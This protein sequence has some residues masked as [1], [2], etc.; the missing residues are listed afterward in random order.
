MSD[1]IIVD[2][3]NLIQAFNE[4]LARNVSLNPSDTNVSIGLSQPLTAI[5]AVLE[6]SIWASD[7]SFAEYHMQVSQE[8]ESIIDEEAQTPKEAF[9]IKNYLYQE[10]YTTDING[11][12]QEDLDFF[13][14]QKQS[15]FNYKEGTAFYKQRYTN[16]FNYQFGGN[17]SKAFDEK[18]FG[19][20]GKV[21]VGFNDKKYDLNFGIEK[22]FDCLIN[23]NLNYAI[24][25]LEF[26]FDFSKQLKKIKE[27]LSQLERDLNPT[28]IFKMICEVGLNFGKNLICPS[29]LVGI[30]LLLP[31]LFGKYSLDL[32]KIRFDWTIAIGAILKTI[33]GALT[34]FVEN[35]PKLIVPFIDCAINSIR[36]VV[37]YI[38][39]IISTTENLYNSIGGS[40][41]QVTKA[42]ITTFQTAGDAL[43]TIGILDT[44][45]EDA[46]EDMKET[47]EDMGDIFSSIA[48]KRNKLSGGIDVGEYER[49]EA[50]EN[51]V[52]YLKT[53]F[54]NPSLR[55]LSEDEV[56][57]SL[58]E[59]LEDYPS[60]IN[61]V[62]GGYSV[63]DINVYKEI[64]KEKEKLDALTKKYF[65]D[66]QVYQ[67]ERLKESKRKNYFRLD[68]V[69]DNRSLSYP[70]GEATLRIAEKEAFSRLMSEYK[71]NN[72][73]A[74]KDD[75]K[76]KTIEFNE[77]AK[78]LGRRM[79]FK[80]TR[81]VINKTKEKRD[82]AAGINSKNKN[83]L[84]PPGEEW[85][86][87][88]YVFAKYGVDIENKYKTST[89]NLLPKAN[90]AKSSSNNVKEFF[91]TYAIKY[92]LELKDYIMQVTGNIILAYKGIE[93]FLGE[94]VE[95]DLKILGNIQELL[96]VIR[97]FRLIYELSSNGFDNCKKIKENKEVFKAM[98][99]ENNQ[100]LTFDDSTLEKQNLDPADYLALKTKDGR[101]ST[102]IDLNK[103]DEA[104]QHLSVNE[105]NLDSIYEGILN[106]LQN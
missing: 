100:E 42:I 63:E 68:F 33:V 49:N 103:C 54:N 76:T 70:D 39:T 47:F 105:N 41:N 101:Y 106:G 104:M 74:S 59:F 82:I 9:S 52:S 51:F 57:L 23:I 90:F 8:T 37:R 15:E 58:I 56:K 32:A 99:E 25:A 48:N 96:H 29:Q 78:K 98:L 89:Y 62:I 102:I 65:K 45:V 55:E 7:M 17:L 44:D 94:Y 81:G 87:Y 91:D 10:C 6:S 93:K 26:T 31:S 34:S 43:E 27:L 16:D 12:R 13:T 73:S 50:L 1:V 83:Y 5:E 95:T 53:R 14:N 67:R 19:K 61:A 36:S 85:N 21:S 35:I 86:W 79:A 28:L 24:P 4:G 80:E 38:S 75:L 64:A 40:V 46:Y 20:D 84:R 72:P 77:S 97:F 11:Q 60:Y 2:I 92:L 30:S 69:G 3:E 88:D 22:C 66:E 71:K 18:F